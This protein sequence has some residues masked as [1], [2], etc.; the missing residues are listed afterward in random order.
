MKRTDYEFIELLGSGQQGKVYK[1]SKDGQIRALKILKI[2]DKNQLALAKAEVSKLEK[3]SKDA[4]NPF[5][6]C[7]FNHYYDFMSSKKLY[8]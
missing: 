6:V 8:A 1:V 3:L 4:C 7:Y 5:I 2:T